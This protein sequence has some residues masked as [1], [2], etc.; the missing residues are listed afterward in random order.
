MTLLFLSIVTILLLAFCITIY[1]SSEFYRQEEYKTRLRQEALTAA[2][3][4]F[5]KEEISPDILKLLAKNQMTVLNKEEIVILNSNNE[6][7]YQ[8]G[9][10]N[11]IIEESIIKDIKIQK[12]VFW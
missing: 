7:I 6:I 1:F 4:L 10:E 9:L 5:N 2:T 11:S 8:S 3:V 12:E